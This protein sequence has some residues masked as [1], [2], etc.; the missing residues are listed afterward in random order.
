MTSFP[1]YLVKLLKTGAI[2]SSTPCGFHK[3][4]L[5]V[6]FMNF[7]LLIFEGQFE[8]FLQAEAKEKKVLQKANL[9]NPCVFSPRSP[10]SSS[11]HLNQE[12]CGH[13]KSSS[14]SSNHS[15]FPANLSRQPQTTSQPPLWLT[16]SVSPKGVQPTAAPSV[17]GGGRLKH[18]WAEWNQ[19]DP[20]SWVQSIKGR[21][22]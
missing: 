15:V 13:Q 3:K 10:P 17:V 7:L 2:S 22:C 8:S 4:V 16:G 14:R 9:T 21:G 11:A 18:F 19:I 6:V 5:N 12:S 1:E 20:D